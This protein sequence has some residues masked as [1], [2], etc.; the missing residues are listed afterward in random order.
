MEFEKETAKVKPEL[1]PSLK[2]FQNQPAQIQIPIKINYAQEVCVV[3]SVAILLIGLVGFVV[4]NLFSAHLSPPHNLI[5]VI[6]GSIGMWC[7]FD[8]LRST[9]IF[10][11]SA[12]LF[13]SAI[14]ILG[15]A[16]GQPGWPTVGNLMHD[17]N[18]WRPISSYLEWGTSDHII[19]L[20][21]GATLLLGAS[22]S[23]KKMT[24]V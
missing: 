12:G 5:L 9:K 3:T 19:H 14:A 18:L 1:K 6:A 23:F 16:L 4:D 20:L 2:P 13:Y 24:H 7:G 11:Y 17:S 8:G 15:F 21:Y 10:S 22:F